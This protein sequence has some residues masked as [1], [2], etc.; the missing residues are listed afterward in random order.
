VRDKHDDRPPGAPPLEEIIGRSKVARARE[1][2]RRTVRE[3][4]EG[5]GEPPH[6]ATDDSSDSGTPLS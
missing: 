2:V 5:A 1:L 4:E 6:E 3:L